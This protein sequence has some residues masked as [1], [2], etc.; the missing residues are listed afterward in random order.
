M[1]ILPSSSVSLPVQL[2]PPCS[3]AG[4]LHSL[5]LTLTPVPQFLEQDP[6]LVQLPQFP[7]TA[8]LLNY[9]ALRNF[10]ASTF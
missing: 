1:E 9:Q 7:S 10:G 2:L 5:V 4:L 3:G 6:K 8:A